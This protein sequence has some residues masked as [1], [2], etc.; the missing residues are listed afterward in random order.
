MTT[1]TPDDPL[2]RDPRVDSA[3]RAASYEEPPPALDAALLAAAHRD[4]GAKPQSLSAQAAM[5]A[6]RRWWPLAAAATVA[7]IAIGVVQRAGHDDLVAP[8]SGGA[9]VS[10]MPERST[11]SPAGPTQSATSA[12]DAAQPGM[13]VPQS[14]EPA[15]GAA[16]SA[17]PAT[18]V[19]KPHER[20]PEAAA[21]AARSESRQR[22]TPGPIVPLEK[23]SEALAGAPGPPAQQQET[24]ANATAPLPEA[25]PGTT[26]KSDSGTARDAAA[27]ARISDDTRQGA[28]L[29]RS[30]AGA[31]GARLAAPQ[32]AAA[33]IP[34]AAAP[35]PSAEQASPSLAPRQPPSPSP[36]SATAPAP[37]PPAA[38]LDES[39]RFAATPAARPRFAAKAVTE[40]AVTEGRAKDRAPLPVSDWIA[41]IRRLRDEGNVGEAAREL[42]AFRAA[43]ADHEKLLP[44]DLRDWHPPEK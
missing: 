16:Q 26:E 41:L 23:K 27:N 17:Q 20:M 3:W 34:S 14:A 24:T 9:V 22:A 44:T 31:P 12:V 7:V 40:G 4:V 15:T 37:M 18:G 28:A 29:Q 32:S 42:A 36:P 38:S 5:H 19:E 30:A 10:D 11:S 25:F 21:P 13:R 43:H 1:H 33:P 8:Q 2:P 39:S 6:R 35:M